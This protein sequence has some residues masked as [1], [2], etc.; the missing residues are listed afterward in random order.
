MKFD[1][2][3]HG[4]SLDGEPDIRHAQDVQDWSQPTGHSSEDDTLGENVKVWDEDEGRSKN[5][6]NPYGQIESS[7]NH[8]HPFSA[9][10][11]HYCDP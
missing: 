3:S 11:F 5:F 8:V 1:D 4:E 2:D 9:S 7:C 10:H 6:K